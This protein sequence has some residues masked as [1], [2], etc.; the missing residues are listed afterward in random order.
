MINIKIP[1]FFENYCNNEIIVQ[2][3]LPGKNIIKDKLSIKELENIGDIL[4]GFYISGIL[5][6]YLHADL[7]PGNFS[8][9][10]DKIN[11]YDFGLVVYFDNREI[12][13]LLKL[14]EYLLKKKKKKFNKFI[15]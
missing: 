15:F 6:G 5:N 2:E 10:N 11:I 13:I 1:F 7:H 14:I 12:K 8:W 4:L 9:N 3:Y